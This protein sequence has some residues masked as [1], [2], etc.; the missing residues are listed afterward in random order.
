MSC[1][2]LRPA[3][4]DHGS[5]GV[6]ALD[7]DDELVLLALLNSRLGTLLGR[8]KRPPTMWPKTSMSASEPASIAVEARM[9]RDSVLRRRLMG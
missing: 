4:L 7:S 3:I 9:T 6:F 2:V 1:R 8:A 5:A